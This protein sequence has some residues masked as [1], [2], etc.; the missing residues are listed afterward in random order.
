MRASSSTTSSMERGPSRKLTTKC[1]QAIS[2]QD[3]D[4]VTGR[5]ATRMAR[6]TQESGRRAGSTEKERSNTPSNNIPGKD[7][8]RMTVWTAN[9]QL[10]IRTEKLGGSFLSTT[11]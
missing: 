4:T 9:I 1:T 8:G 6:S 5:S 10:H 2:S 7:T 3:S 11:S